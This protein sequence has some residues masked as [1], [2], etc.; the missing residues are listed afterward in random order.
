MKYVSVYS[1]KGSRER[2]FKTFSNSRSASS[3]KRRV[4]MIAEYRRAII[5]RSGPLNH[6]PGRGYGDTG[7]RVTMTAVHAVAKALKTLYWNQ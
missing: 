7:R 1:R 3:A 5:A 6:A 2:Q 4:F